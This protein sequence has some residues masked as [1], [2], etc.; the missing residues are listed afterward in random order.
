MNAYWW[1]GLVLAII[2]FAFG[3]AYAFKHPA[4]QNTLSRWIHNL[5]S[6]WPL[7]IFIMGMLVGALAVHFFWNWCPDLGVGVG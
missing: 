7:S 4:R 5:G 1:T 3:E 2:F 6:T